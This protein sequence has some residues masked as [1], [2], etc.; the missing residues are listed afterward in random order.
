MTSSAG[1]GLILRPSGTRKVAITEDNVAINPPAL[2]PNVYW[3]AAAP[4]ADEIGLVASWG[5]PLQRLFDLSDTIDIEKAAAALEMLS[6]ALP[7]DIRVPGLNA[8]HGLLRLMS[9]ADRIK[10]PFEDSILTGKLDSVFVGNALTPRQVLSSTLHQI[11]IESLK[12]PAS[13][14]RR[15]I[16]HNP[17]TIKAGMYYL[18]VISGKGVL[19]NLTGK[20]YWAT[21]EQ[22][23]Y[24]RAKCKINIVKSVQLLGESAPVK[25]T[26]HPALTQYM[27]NRPTDP[28]ARK[29]FDSLW[30]NFLLDIPRDDKSLHPYSMMLRG[31]LWVLTAKKAAALRSDGFNVTKFNHVDVWADQI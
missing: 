14:T 18:E 31:Q 25:L 7:L 19:A 16:M 11:P 12:L 4:T 23:V 3:L 22:A 26:N 29:L 24:L 13:F 15:K 30:L 17:K 1:V 21:S 10:R 6:K 27:A 20:S 9:V 5:G 8:R 28:E 2:S